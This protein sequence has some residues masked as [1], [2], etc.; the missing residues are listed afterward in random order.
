MIKVKFSNVEEFVQDLA[1]YNQGVSKNIRCTTQYRPGLIPQMKLVSVIAA[2]R[3]GDELI[4]LEQ[5]CGEIVGD[6]QQVSERAKLKQ[7]DIY[8]KIEEFASVHDMEV[9]GGIYA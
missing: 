2:C 3:V 1:T 8:Q 5:F 6:D 7:G 4:E 9:R